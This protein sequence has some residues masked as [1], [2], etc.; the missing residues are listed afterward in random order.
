MKRIML[1]KSMAA[2]VTSADDFAEKAEKMH[3]IPCIIIIIII[4]YS[5]KDDNNH[6][7][8]LDCTQEV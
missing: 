1:D 8:K 5:S 2:L 4:I 6:I 3:D 7:I